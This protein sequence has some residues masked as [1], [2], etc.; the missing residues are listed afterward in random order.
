MNWSRQV[1]HVM[2]K[3]LRESRWA[4]GVYAALT[5]VATANAFR[6]VQNGPTT[7]IAMPLI[8]LFGMITVGSIVQSDSPIRADAFWASRPL[9]ASAVLAAKLSLALAVVIGVAAI[10]QS[11][12]LAA[13]HLI[14]R[15]LPGALYDSI[16]DYARWLLIAMVIAAVTRDL[17]TFIVALLVVPVCYLLNVAQFDGRV[18]DPAMTW[19]NWVLGMLPVIMPVF[20]VIGGAALL[21][22][23]YSKRDARIRTSVAAFMVVVSGTNS[24]ASSTTVGLHTGGVDVVTNVE[25]M[26]EVDSTALKEPHTTFTLVPR[27]LDAIKVGGLPMFGLQLNAD[28][29][30]STRRLMLLGATA[31]FHMRNGTVLRERIDGS[32][33]PTRAGMHAP[34]ATVWLDPRYPH[35]TTLPV[36]APLS[37]SVR[38]AVETDLISLGMDGEILVSVPAFVD[39]LSL[40]GDS[41]SEHDGVRTTVSNWSYGS[42]AATLVVNSSTLTR[43]GTPLGAL[44]RANP[45]DA[46]YALVNTARHEAI[47]LSVGN[48]GTQE[49]WIVLPGVQTTVS[50]A[51]LSTPE[52]YVDQSGN[53]VDDA[54]FRD[55]RLVITY[56][57]SRESYPI[58]SEVAVPPRSTPLP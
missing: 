56:W 40:H 22:Y 30:P 18:Y 15:S 42:G 1:A 28:S 24:P 48:F 53:R 20:F 8:V 51:H 55:A 9:S 45:T 29:L 4:I 31:I 36:M 25:E 17:R 37:D 14:L 12:G 3:D 23:L 6:A 50:N 47:S 32:W 33:N 34:S 7:V 58:H 39:T 2:A 44:L 52:R 19:R 26:E 13:H 21:A 41:V 46:D 11:I 27:T 57:K 54:W 49:G 16:L 43:D 35:P 38:H 5:I 10:G